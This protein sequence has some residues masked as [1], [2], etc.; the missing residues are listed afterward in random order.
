MAF[1]IKYNSFVKQILVLFIGLLSGVSGVIAQVCDNDHIREHPRPVVL[2]VGGTNNAPVAFTVLMNNIPGIQVS[3]SYRWEREAAGVWVDAI[4]VGA[5]TNEYFAT[6]PG[7]YRCVVT[8]R[9][10][11]DNSILCQQISNPAMLTEARIEQQPQAPEGGSICTGENHIF[12]VPIGYSANANVSDYSYN[13]VWERQTSSGG[14]E[15]AGAN[16]NLQIFNTSQAGTYRC[17]VSVIIWNGNTN[18]CS[19]T[20]GS[21]SF[22][23]HGPPNAPEVTSRSVCVYEDSYISNAV[24]ASIVDN[25]RPLTEYEWRFN[26]PVPIIESG[27]VTNNTVPRLEILSSIFANDDNII[28]NNINYT[29]TI[30]NSCGEATSDVK[31]M[32]I[33]DRP[34]PPTPNNRTY[35]Q[36]DP[37]TPM[38]VFEQNRTF[39]FEADGAPRSAPPVPTTTNPTPPGQPQSWLVSHEVDYIVNNVVDVTC[40]SHRATATVIVRGL[41][42]TPKFFMQVGE[43]T[44]ESGKGDGV[45][46]D[47]W[48]CLNTQDVTINAEGTSIRWYDRDKNQISVASSVQINTSLPGLQTYFVTQTQ[49]DLCESL[50]DP[51]SI[52]IL[53]RGVA[54]VED[55]QLSH[56]LSDFCPLE[57]ETI[58]ISSFTPGA[59]YRWYSSPD[60]EP[61]TFLGTGDTFTTEPLGLPPSDNLAVHSFYV[62][63]EHSGLCESHNTKAAVLYVRD[64]ELP[65]F[66]VPGQIGQVLP[67]IVVTSDPSECR[68]TIN[69]ERLQV[70]DRC[71]AEEDLEIFFIKPYDPDVNEE[72][73]IDFIPGDHFFNVGDTT[74]T[75]W[76]K[77]LAGNREYSLQSIQVI[78]REKPRGGCPTDIVWNIDENEYSAIVFYELNYTDNCGVEDLVFE[79]NRGE[80]SGSQF[81]LGEHL[82]RYYISDRAGNVD[83]CAFNINV[84]RPPRRMEVDLITDR[85]E[86]CPNEPVVITP[87]IS[88]GTGR[89][90]FSWK[91][92]GRITAVMEDFPTVNTTYELTVSDGDT[93]IFRSLD[94]SVLQRPPVSLEIEGRRMEE[95]FEG[96]EVL[97]TA[98]PGFESYKLLL[99]DQV[100]QLTGPNHSV[101]FTAEIGM[102]DVQVFAT[103]VNGCVAEDFLRVHVESKILP[104]VFT[105]NLDGKNDVFLQGFLREGDVLQV[106]N[107]AGLMLYEGYEGWDGYYRGTRM[108]QGTYLYVVRRRMNNGE[109]RLFTGNVT[110]IL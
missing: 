7:N 95:I 46:H 108:P 36:G 15:S 4:G 87:I 22:V 67:S 47:F 23:V 20:S 55:V 107:R 12:S 65:E 17:I 98:T 30:R 82:I 74:L 48:K 81:P 96:E 39:W 68:A 3:Y 54:S 109:I 63:I 10:Q 71:T 99:Q 37:V 64:I 58:S 86:V 92:F 45:A 42:E 49:T 72:E 9:Q 66:R 50:I 62:S 59:T 27:S 78:D 14:W 69:L 38:S 51:G 110:L 57:T 41:S 97:V 34:S 32:I 93:T 2:C 76:V 85:F 26:S 35:C 79:R 94:I 89:N 1:L 88:G 28:V 100:L 11:S 53:I 5:L 40:I 31:R 83:T 6:I 91:P 90:T 56:R 13:H 75:W 104:N 43:D 44:E 73:T 8:V 52:V 25:G 21:A 61:E 84:R 105:P 18:V 24:P 102:F 101:S 77:D 19:F 106:F 29:L 16:S 103:D 60:K 80:P 33:R 70:W